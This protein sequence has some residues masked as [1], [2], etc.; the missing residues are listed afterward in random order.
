MSVLSFCLIG[1]GFIGP[2]HARNIAQHPAALLRY[3]VDLDLTAA[4]RLADPLDAV[5]VTLDEALADKSVDAVAICTPPRT[6]VMLI[7]RA[8]LAGKAIF[9]EKP[10]DLDLSKVD[11]CG[12]GPAPFGRALLRRLQSSFRSHS[13]R[14][15]RSDPRRRVSLT[16]S[17]NGGLAHVNSSFR[18]IYGYDQRVEAFGPKGMLIS[19]NRQPTLLERYSAVGIRQDALQ[20]FFI[21]RYVEAYKAELNHF[22]EAVNLGTPLSIGFREG[23]L[24]LRIA[25]AAMQSAK[26]GLPVRLQE[27][28]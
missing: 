22:I 17:E 19:R 27:D 5:V 20:H 2:V 7:E 12:E 3:V 11:S 23:R 25:Y 26:A 10:I 8:A 6:H 1:A 15:R 4:H 13:R 28:P 14:A 9:C 21:D 18:A 24:A 16:E